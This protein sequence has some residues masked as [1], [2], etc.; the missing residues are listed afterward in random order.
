MSTKGIPAWGCDCTRS[1]TPRSR[2]HRGSGS[3]TVSWG[4]PTVP[5]PWVV[6]E[7]MTQTGRSQR[8]PLPLLSLAP[9][10]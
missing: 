4:G 8:D 2:I 3:E 6:R 9:T 5:E 1:P 7:K 10:Q